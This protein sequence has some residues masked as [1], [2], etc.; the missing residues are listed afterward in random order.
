MSLTIERPPAAAPT[1]APEPPRWTRLWNRRLEHYPDTKAR[2]GYLSIVVA[3]TVLLYWQ[4]YVDGGAAT[5]ILRDLNMSFLYFTGLTA[6]GAA[7]GAFASLAA[8]LADRWG[9]ANLVAWG[10]A[11]TSLITLVGFPLCDTKLEFAACFG[12]LSL[13]E[14]VVLVGTAA[15]VR[16][17][18]PQIGRGSAMGFWTLGPVLGSLVVTV[19]AS[20]TLDRYDSWQSQFIICGIA[21]AVIAVAAIFF[22]RE[23]S[24]NLRDQVMVDMDDRELL[25]RRAQNGEG[26]EHA[27]GVRAFGAVAKARVLGPALGISLALVFYYTLVAFAV[28]LLAT[29]FGYSESRANGLVSWYWITCAIGLVITGLLSDR[30]RVRKPFLLIGGA[31]FALL[32]IVFIGKLTDPATDYATLR[33]LLIGMAA[34]QA[35]LYVPWMAAYT[36]TLEDIHPSLV[37]TGLAVWGWIIRIIVCGLFLALPHVVSGVSTLVEAPAPAVL[38]AQGGKLQAEQVALERQ[39]AA[40]K[41]RE[42]ALKS[43][44]AKLKGKAERA[45][46]AGITPTPTQIAAAKAEQ[47]RLVAAGAQLQREAATLQQQVASLKTRGAAFQASV[48]ELKTTATAVPKRWQTWLWLCVLGQVLFIPLA[49]LLRGRW[50]PRAAAADLSRH[51]VEVDRALARMEAETQA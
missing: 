49:L 18:S 8:G 21:G 20:Q 33:L 10:V 25:E 24:P 15:L 11:V 29:T 9:R 28:V 13:V 23:L 47:A 31:G 22:L 2:V 37:A 30:V 17:F 38:Q 12:A 7:I 4:L 36:E 39:G 34:F 19:V 50:S 1:A 40:L 26:I 16:D 6:A 46:A 45:A 48:A 35:L 27:S 43:D 5:R 44:G 3:V 32:T 42:V 51:D 14:G 41:A